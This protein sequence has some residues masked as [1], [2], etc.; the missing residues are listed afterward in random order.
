[1][2]W[3]QFAQSQL[4]APELILTTPSSDGFLGLVIVSIF[5][6]LVVPVIVRIC[7]PTG[8]IVF[9][10]SCGF[11]AVMVQAVFIWPWFQV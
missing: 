8:S 11:V 4:D 7:I 1:M 3:I 10:I 5:L 9:A 6:I 2:K